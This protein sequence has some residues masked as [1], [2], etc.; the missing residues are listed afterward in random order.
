ME[1]EDLPIVGPGDAETVH[2]NPEVGFAP[3]F[4]G[5]PPQGGLG[6]H[7]IL[8]M[9]FRHKRKI[10]T[11]TVTGL[12][13]AGV[14]YFA[15]PPAYES[16][17]KLLVRYVMERS[18]VDGLESQ[19]KTPTP[20][21][22][23]LINS[24]VEILNSTDLIRQVAEAIGV[25]RFAAGSPSEAT[26]QKA[27]EAIAKDLDV[28]VVKDTNIISVAFRSSDP[29]LP[30]PVVQEVVKRYFDKHLAVH[31]S[32]GAFDF[33][34]QET[35]NLKQQLAQTEAE[36]KQA[37]ESAGIIS[38]AEAKTDIA[39]EIGKTQQELDGDVADLAA[40]QARVKDLQKSLALP[41]AQANVAPGQPVTGDVLEKYKSVV[42]R[43]S[44]LQKAENDLLLKYTPENPMV[45]AKAAQVADLERQRSDL[46]KTYPALVDTAAAASVTGAAQPNVAGERAIL[47][48][49][50]SKVT[51]LQNRMSTLEAR[52][53]VIS[54]AAPK[55]EELERK[56]Q[57]EETNYRASETSLEK[58]QIDETLDPSRMP[59]ISIVQ[60]PSPAA[61][62][63]RNLEKIV[64]GIAGGGVA[65]GIGIM[66]LI[67]LILD[68]SVKRS[69]E[70]E[71]RL[72]VP[73]LLTIP[74][75]NTGLR[76]LRLRNVGEETQPDNESDRQRLSVLEGPDGLLRPFYEAIR[77]RLGVF[78]ENNNM[79]YRPKLVG[80]TGLA[81]NAGTS[82]LAA[83]LATAISEASEGRVLLVDK[84]PSPR[85]FYNSLKEFKRSDLEYVIF[86]MPA[87]G[88]TSST[89]PLARFMDT[90]L[91]VVEA[92]KSN[93]QSVKR[94]Y[95]QLAA[96]TKVSV[97]LNKARSYG[98]KWLEGDI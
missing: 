70:L 45:K 62:V 6:L 5:L 86:D 69:V 15:S 38:L 33:V 95:A 92:E 26:T 85:E 32:T 66:L 90:V 19:I 23:T 10:L 37:K 49:L 39:T 88:P 18:A 43:L 51:A 91:L 93:R 58:A 57:V 67:E 73:L 71:K 36:L 22:H 68:Q 3:N 40:Q 80:V 31:R 84:I 83:G 72:Q 96:K 27:V 65:I 78:F 79:N 56:A 74:Y 42:G 50:E 20:E 28:T 52:A 16:E 24:E 12:L 29:T 97:I 14:F 60:A 82:S 54:D 63:K 8:F 4:D 30:M 87:F 44:G 41:A 13:A 75:L 21:N 98:P 7:D 81:K 53:K 48:G 77:D 89:L 35:A 1:K 59:N 94:A 17:A 46:E 55:I 9:L 34:R 47:A 64:M 2:L 25:S 11:L 76:R 61:K